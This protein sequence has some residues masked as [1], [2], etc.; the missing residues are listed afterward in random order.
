MRVRELMIEDVRTTSRAEDAGSA[1]FHME[2]DDIHHLVVMNGG[3]IEGVVSSDDLGGPAGEGIRRGRTVGDLMSP[4]SAV[5]TPDMTVR[6][7]ANRLR[8][9]R[10]GC[11][12]VVEKGRLVG[13]LTATDV[14]NWVGSGKARTQRVSLTRAGRQFKFESSGKMRRGARH[15]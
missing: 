9:R 5:A 2:R 1:F 4:S 13:I 15:A 6:Q 3:D 12:P 11:L 7:A 14:C 10:I 8:G